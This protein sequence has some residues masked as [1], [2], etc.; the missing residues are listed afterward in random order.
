MTT[1]DNVATLSLTRPLN[2]DEL[3]Q[4]THLKALLIATNVQGITGTALII[5]EI[6]TPAAI[7]LPQFVQDVYRGSL[8]SN[9][10]LTFEPVSIVADTFAADVKLELLSD[11]YALFTVTK[12]SDDIISIDLVAPLTE[13]DVADRTYLTTVLHATR[14]NVGETAVV[15]L[16]K[17][18]ITTP[19]PTIPTP[20]FS[21]PIFRGS[22]DDY[23]QLR[24]IDAVT[25]V[26]SSYTTGVQ[27]RLIGD[28][29]ALFT[30]TATAHSLQIV[31]VPGLT[32]DNLLGK[33]FLSFRV[34]ASHPET[35]T[36][37]AGVLIDIPAKECALD[38]TP[39]FENLVYTMALSTTAKGLL[40]QIRARVPGNEQRAM[41]YA[42]GTIDDG[43]VGRL[44]LDAT[45]GE[46][47]LIDNL[48]VGQYKAQVTAQD[49]STALT[50]SAEVRL[51]VSDVDTCPPEATLH[52]V[53]NSLLVKNLIENKE[54]LDIM[55]STIGSECSF[56]VKK[57]NPDDVMYVRIDA[58]TKMLTSVQFDREA[59]IFA[60]MAVPQIQVTLELIC[61]DDITELTVNI[62]QRQFAEY[63][64]ETVRSSDASRSL[65]P[66]ASDGRW[67][68]LT[69]TLPYAARLTHLSIIIED[70]NDNAPQFVVPLL[71]N[72]LFGYPDALL[73]EQIMPPQLLRVYAIDRD[74]GLNALVRYSLVENAHFQ[75]DGVTGSVTPLRSAL[76]LAAGD[77]EPLELVVRAT[78]RDGAADGL[79]SERSV[80]VRRLLAEHITVISV[81]E[82]GLE[83]AERVVDR[84]YT[85]T[86]L[87]LK[88]LHSA[89]I[90]VHGD[91]SSTA[92]QQDHSNVLRM[93]A[94]AVNADSTGFMQS[95]EVQNALHGFDANLSAMTFA[96]HQAAIG[97]TSANTDQV[98]LVVLC[99]V[100]GV[101]LLLTG[102]GTFVMWWYKIRP[103]E[104]RQ[105]EDGDSVASGREPVIGRMEPSAVVVQPEFGLINRGFANNSPKGVLTLNGS[106]TQG[107]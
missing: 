100:L 87:E 52:H 74:V 43:L 88:I 31:L 69:D 19:R 92:R 2:D 90:S 36:A 17:L 24:T 37:S 47:S 102:I 67:Y 41:R 35:D 46:L 62:D 34:E 84:V 25:L 93:F 78:D 28:D 61:D 9:L 51:T 104:Y 16:V 65:D 58:A 22:I 14:P 97:P 99:A 13:A 76:T 3:R 8:D 77:A 6:T 56:V 94:Y 4:K 85:A 23:L 81:Q 5:V 91:A 38:E 15:L 105:M 49:A 45:T 12:T 79:Q 70:E 106:T 29:S 95:T 63:S 98:A 73:A 18:D 83:D 50:G 48:G 107:D 59:D 101:L 96:Q 39:I 71:D 64:N 57:S 103:Y 10:A 53:D 30:F 33:D 68:T 80:L 1:V 60:S 89:R 20:R 40:G 27:F 44:A 26:E 66:M 11:D 32:A 54:H 55:P 21:Q 86:G 42:F 75:I 82:Q 7:P 72:I